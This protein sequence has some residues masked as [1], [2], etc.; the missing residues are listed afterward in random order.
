MPARIGLVTLSLCLL[1]ANAFAQLVSTAPGAQPQG[2]QKPV[3][4]FFAQ[5]GGTR[6]VLESIVIPPKAQ[7]PFSLLLQTEWVKT[8]SDG[9]T[10]TSVNER[11]IARDSKGRIYQERWFLVPKNGKI[12]SKMT[13]IQISDPNTHTHYNCFM[14]E[15]PHQCVLS[16]FTPS[17]SAIYK[18]ESPSTG[19]LPDEAGSVIHDNLGKQ[20]ISGVETV[21]TKDAVIYNPGVFGN[22]RKVTVEREFWYSQQLGINLLSKR[23]DP[24]FGTQTFTATNLILSEP[25]VHLFDLPTGFTVVDRRQ[26]APPEN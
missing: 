1:A 19:A 20:L 2:A 21:G 13:T 15:E 18:F 12:E 25:D 26:T 14:L 17:T 11:R 3:Q 6:E 10:I 23:S 8:L 16:T 7:A 22:D 24:R 5:D 4:Q 9:G